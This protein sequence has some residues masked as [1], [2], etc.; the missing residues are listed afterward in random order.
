MRRLILFAAVQALLGAAWAQSIVNVRITAG[1]CGRF[2][3]DGERYERAA[4]FFWPEGSPHSLYVIPTYMITA[5]VA[6]NTSGT[7]LDAGGDEVPTPT[8]IY[9]DP[10]HTSYTFASSYSYL[11]DVIIDRGTGIPPMNCAAGPTAGQL[12]V[13]GVCWEHDGGFWVQDGEV[14]DVIAHPPPGWVFTDGA[15][16][17]QA[18]IKHRPSGC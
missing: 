12:L 9:A 11:I 13:N 18:S 3:V 17:S 1:P 6:C 4:M 16:C 10:A 7:A 14:L 8:V 5:A 15:A 2:Y